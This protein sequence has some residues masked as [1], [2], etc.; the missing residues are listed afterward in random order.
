MAIGLLDIHGFA[1][2]VQT[3]DLLWRCVI[4]QKLLVVMGY[5]TEKGQIEHMDANIARPVDQIAV[6]VT[7]M[8]L[9]VGQFGVFHHFGATLP[10][11]HHADF[12]HGVG[13]SY[14]LAGH[15]RPDALVKPEKRRIGHLNQGVIDLSLIHI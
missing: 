6:F 5:T 11:R 10:G 2:L 14:D 1:V 15:F 12:L 13:F 7:R 8:A 3:G 4:G 9:F